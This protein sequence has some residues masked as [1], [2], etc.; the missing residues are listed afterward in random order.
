ME[1]RL[2]GEFAFALRL[3]LNAPEASA[4]FRRAE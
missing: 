1:A 2:E 3:Q 4:E